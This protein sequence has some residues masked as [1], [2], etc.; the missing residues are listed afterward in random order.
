MVR[1]TGNIE[2]NLEHEDLDLWKTRLKRLR[3]IH[4][5]R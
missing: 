5:V 1:D 3:K 4:G 2:M